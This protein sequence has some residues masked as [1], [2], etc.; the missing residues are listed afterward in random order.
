MVILPVVSLF[1]LLGDF[2]TDV[3]EDTPARFVIDRVI[4]MRILDRNLLI[5]NLFIY[6]TLN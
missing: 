6:A 2:L 5:Y 4:H 3:P 1:K